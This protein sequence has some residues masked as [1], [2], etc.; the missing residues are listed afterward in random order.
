[1]ST[2]ER[3]M[4]QEKYKNKRFQDIPSDELETAISYFV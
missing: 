1:M 3:Q 2:E 4:G